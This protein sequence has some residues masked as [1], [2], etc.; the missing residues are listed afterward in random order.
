MINIITD[1]LVL[2]MLY[3]M[4]IYSMRFIAFPKHKEN[5]NG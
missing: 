1:Y 3:A 4:L 2:I 5:K